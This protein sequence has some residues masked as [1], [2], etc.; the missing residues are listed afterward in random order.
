MNIAFPLLFL[1]S[2]AFADT[3]E[4]KLSGMTCSGCKKMV[5]AAVCDVPGIKT[6]EIEIG[7]MKLVAEEGKTLDQSAIAKALEDL[8]KKTNSEYKISSA[9]D[10][11]LN[12]THIEMSPTSDT[13]KEKK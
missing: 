4:Y 8:N 5:K 10:I 13:K 2:I 3:Y 11:S 6:C 7:S 9:T 1:V 12:N